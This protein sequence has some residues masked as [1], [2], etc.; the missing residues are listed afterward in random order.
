MGRLFFENYNGL[1]G[2]FWGKK[3][4]AGTVGLTTTK[5]KEG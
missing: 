5:K 4:T 2:G 3:N 1:K